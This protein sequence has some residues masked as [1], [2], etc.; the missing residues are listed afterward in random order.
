[1]QSVLFYDQYF[2][3]L[4]IGLTAI[5][6]CFKMGALV[7]PRGQFFIEASILVGYAFLSNFRLRSGIKGNKIEDKHGM[8]VLI[9]LSIFTT[10]GNTYFLFY[11]TYILVIEAWLQVAAMAFTIFEVVLAIF[12]MMHFTILD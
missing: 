12:A 8:T 1:M 7:Y 3:V 4:V 5:L 9:L 11:Q 10:F 6:L 2:C